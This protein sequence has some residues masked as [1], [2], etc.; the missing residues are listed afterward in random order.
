MKTL[1]NFILEARGSF[2]SQDN[3]LEKGIRIDYSDGFGKLL[4]E[5]D[6]FDYESK[7]KENAAEMAKKWYEKNPRKRTYN[8]KVTLHVCATKDRNKIGS[9]TYAEVL[10]ICKDAG[11]SWPWSDTKHGLIYARAEMACDHKTKI[12]SAKI[13]S[14]IHPEYGAKL[15]EEYG[16]GYNNLPGEIST[17]WRERVFSCV[18]SC[19]LVED[20]WMDNDF[21]EMDITWTYIPKFNE[22]KLKKVLKELQSDPELAKYAD[23]LD[24][25]RQGIQAYYDEKRANGDYYTGD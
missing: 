6:K 10:D 4:A 25:T 24:S 20:V 17:E 14:Y 21:Q 1:Y 15:E 9:K 23:R 13:R 19:D 16:N 8:G 3:V 12:D 11:M 7:L 2:I 18:D 5:A 22:S